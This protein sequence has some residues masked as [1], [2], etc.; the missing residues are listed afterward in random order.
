MVRLKLRQLD[1]S[2]ALVGGI[3]L[4]L[5]L[6]Y[7]VESAKSATFDTP[8]ID[9]GEYHAA[10][11]R[12]AQGKPLIDD[13]FWQPPLFPLLLGCLYRVVGP[14][15]LIARVVLAILATLSCLLVWW[16]GLRLFSRRSGVVAGLMAAAYGPFLFFST[17][18]LPTDL[19]VFLDLLALALWLRC[20]EQS[21]WHRWLA[22]GFVVGA[23]TITVPNA[24][25]LL[26]VG[27]F[28]ALAAPY[29]AGDR[30]P[31]YS[32]VKAG[33]ITMLA[34]AVPIGSVTIRNHLVSG[35]TV[36]ISTNGGINFYIGNNPESDEA[37]A[38][39]PGEQWKRLARESYRDGART[40]AEQNV[41]FFRRGVTYLAEEPLAFLR[42]LAR[43]T[44]R[45]L[46]AREIPRNLD[47]YVYRDYSHL[48]SILM[49]RAGPFTF[50]FGLMAPLA[51]LG[52]V[53]S[54]AA[55]W[56]RADEAADSASARSSSAGADRYPLDPGAPAGLPLR[57]QLAARIGGLGF[58]LMYGAS[59]TLF[60]VSSRY[61]LPMAIVMTLFAAAGVVWVWDQWRARDRRPGRRLRRAALLT[62]VVAAAVVN[63]PITTPT[64]RVNFRAELAM[65]LGHHFATEGRLD[66]AEAHLDNALKPDPRYAAAA[67][68]AELLARTGRADQAERLLEEAVTWDEKSAET[69]WLLG[70]VRHEQGRAADAVAMFEKALAIDPTSS[71]VRGNLA[72]VLA[73]VGRLDEAINQYRQAVDLAD[74]PGPLLIRLGDALAR[75]G[76]YREAIEA[77]RLGLWQV[78]PD[79]ETLNRVAWLL[80]T[81]PV[82]ELRDCRRAIEIAEHLCSITDYGHPVALD[83]L[84]AAYAECGRWAEAVTWVERAIDL[85]LANNDL[86]TA[87][88]LRPRLE[89][90]K[91]KLSKPPP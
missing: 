24:A 5:Q 71:K 86:E 12:F 88:S 18:L 1:W 38:I 19:A 6:I 26:A 55:V 37:V 68:L 49:W 79:P 11:V 56:R 69:R 23:A 67:H 2:A 36:V 35:E 61:R 78:E 8:I 65:C 7:L 91:D 59:I 64:D 9:A 41:Y 81:C 63:A 32:A 3:C 77:Y 73:D 80:A 72:D 10:A 42:G 51:A 45:L 90:Y 43:K 17:E 34:A 60:F 46:N 53:V 57:C 28:G 20:L 16:I 89:I 40:R 83:T 27:V 30:R 62:F 84:A 82:V 52:A 14:S 44:I 33:A 39:R 22:F 13:A 66:E 50:P 76:A 87:D 58:I 15:V 75:R 25:V 70:L 4:T 47:P 29:L 21:R 85:A 74:A 54:L 48:L 31:I